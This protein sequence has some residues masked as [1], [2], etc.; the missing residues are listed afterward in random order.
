[1]FVTRIHWRIFSLLALLMTSA[2]CL[3]ASSEAIDLQGKPIDPLQASHGKVV[4][5]VF[6]RTDCPVSSR[7]APT[8]EALSKRYAQNAEFWLVD[9]DKTEQ[10]SAVKKYLADYSYSLP[11]LRDPEHVLV[12]RSQVK[13]TPEAAVFDPHGKLVYHG[14]IDDWYADFG[15]ARPAPTTHELSDAIRDTIAGRTPQV[16]SAQAVGCYISDLD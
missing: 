9:P 11:A 4:V 12:T 16:S 6:V 5:L 14:R 10:A 7:Y 1:M 15:R 2:G 3:G 8:I 13:I